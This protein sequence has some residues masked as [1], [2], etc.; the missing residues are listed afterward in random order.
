MHALG[1]ACIV[2]VEHLFGFLAQE[3]LAIL[4]I[5]IGGGTGSADDL[6][7]RNATGGFGILLQDAGS[8]FLQ[9]QNSRLVTLFRTAA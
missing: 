5:T 4:G 2:V 6:L 7:G 9:I 1:L 3:R 8:S